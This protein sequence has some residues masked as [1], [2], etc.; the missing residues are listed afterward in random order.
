[1][2]W[3]KG[4]FTGKTRLINGNIYGFPLKIYLKALNLNQSIEW[5]N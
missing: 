1:M 3:F 5:F 2:D 4:T